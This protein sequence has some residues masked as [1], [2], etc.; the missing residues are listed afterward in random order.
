MVYFLAF[1][2]NMA[3]FYFILSNLFTSPSN[4]TLSAFLRDLNGL[5]RTLFGLRLSQIK[6]D[7]EEGLE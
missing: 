2:C 6:M 1:I 3:E 7:K 5:N 4:L